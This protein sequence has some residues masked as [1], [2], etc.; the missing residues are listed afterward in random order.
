MVSDMVGKRVK[1]KDKNNNINIWE[2]EKE[3]GSVLKIQHKDYITFINKKD[4]K[5]ILN[6]DD[7]ISETVDSVI[8]NVKFEETPD[9]YEMNG[10]LDDMH[11]ETC[12]NCGREFNNGKEVQEELIYNDEAGLYECKKCKK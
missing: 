3:I 9:T 6:N 8:R 12:R 5:M 10:L 4:I 7:Y 2:I 1:I 11:S